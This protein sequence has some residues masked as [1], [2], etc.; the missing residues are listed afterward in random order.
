MNYRI[1][2]SLVFVCLATAPAEA[3][4]RVNS[5]KETA[6]RSVEGRVNGKIDQGINRGLDKVEQGIGNI[7]KKKD[8]KPD[9]KGQKTDDAYGNEDQP[10]E[11]DDTASGKNSQGNGAGAGNTGPAPLKAYSKFDFVPGEKVIAYEDFAQD[12]VGDFPAKWNTNASGEIVTIE[13]SEAKWL[14]FATKGI[15]FPEFVNALPENFTMEFDMAVTDDISEHQSGLKIYF[16]VQKERTLQFDQMF[17][18]QIQAGIDIH[19]TQNISTSS[20]WV[21]GKA[22]EKIMENTMP[23]SWK[24]GASNHVSIWKQKTRLRIYVNEAKLWDIPKAFLPD[25]TYSMLFA[26]YM[27]DGSAFL[28][29]LRVAVGAPDTRSKL[30]T[31]G[32]LVTRGILFDVNKAVIKP[33]SYG[34]LKEIATVLKE[35]PAVRVKIVGHTDADGDDASNLTLSKKRSEAVK[36]AL[37]GEFGIDAARMETDGKG[38]SQPSEPNTT[39]SGKANNRRVEFIKL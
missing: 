14:Q 3:Q 25:Q 7:F 31:E 37:T 18:S 32:K 20:V 35:N 28:S 1:S 30:L 10:Q 8:K 19:P 24:V 21:F 26:T 34:T 9:K 2:I 27:F 38:E 12:A 36:A 6:E 29:N 13:G 5:P 11:S 22:E 15:Y 17:S 39:A 16:P 33:E 4:I 23:F